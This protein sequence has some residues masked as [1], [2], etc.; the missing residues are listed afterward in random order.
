MPFHL[1]SFQN[2]FL[3][4]GGDTVDAIVTVT[5]DGADAASVTARERV[6]GFIADVSGSME[7]ARIDAL[8]HAIQ[9]AIEELDPETTFFV[10]AFN[11][12]AEVVAP[13]NPATPA[14]KDLARRRVSLLR[15]SGGTAMSSGLEMALSYFRGFPRAIN[16]AVFI[17][18]GKNESEGI[19]RVRGVL[20]L[21]SGVF[22]CDC[23]GIGTDWQVGEVQEIARAL[24]GKASIIPEPGG[25]AAAFRAAVA[26]AQSK[27]MNNVRLRLW[28]PMGAEL[29][30]V[31]QVN[32]TIEDLAARAVQVGPL[33]RDY[34]TGAWAD[35]ESR[36]YHVTVHVQPGGVGDELLAC[37]PSV[38]MTQLDGGTSSDQEVREPSARIFAAWT[39]DDAL[40]SRL[41]AHVAHYTGQDQLATAIQRGL[42]ARDRGDTAAATQLLGRAVQLA[43]QSGNDDMTSRLRRVVDI[44]DP[45]QGT[46]RLKQHVDRAATMDLQLESTT[47][48]RA[49]RAPVEESV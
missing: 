22:A 5:L 49:R 13:P 17:T 34:P 38:V 2:R 18:D 35:G 21:C 8:R 4:P 10:V 39:P 43:H 47:T 19:D 14:S 46:V 1:E 7:G 16:Q 40:S 24:D 31:Q 12:E 20:A 6:I 41:D 27:T 37:R 42:E 45:V 28:T 36:D 48:K 33:V 29:V 25:V 44:Q 15:A 32:P 9:T 26:K 23:W 3:P 11:H 30:R